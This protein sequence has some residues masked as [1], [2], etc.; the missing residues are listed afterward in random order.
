M[1]INASHQITTT[2]P[3]I[4][5]LVIF[6]DRFVSQLGLTVLCGPPNAHITVP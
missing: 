2:V 5:H 6:R 3:S 4:L 1:D